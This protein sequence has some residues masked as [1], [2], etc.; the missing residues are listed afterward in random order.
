MKAELKPPYNIIDKFVALLAISRRINSER[1]FDELLDIITVEAAKL[2]DAER[3]AIFLLDKAT[4]QL[5]ARTALGVSDTIRFDSRLGIAGAV[6]MSG[7][8]MIVED[9]YRSPHF[10]PSVDSQTGFQTR[11]IL[12]VPL[13]NMRR[14]IIGVFQVLNKKDGKFTSEDEQLVENLAVHAAIALE[15]AKTLNEL[16]NRQQQLIAE[17][18]NLR[19]EVEERF[20]TKSILGTTARMDQIRALINRTA[21]S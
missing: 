5:W 21:Q 12:S 19:K 1:D 4:N 13:R 7:K 18:E 16:E 14:E 6:L 17:N 20:T 10:Y 15:N 2:L 3:A 8:N 11:N 9:A